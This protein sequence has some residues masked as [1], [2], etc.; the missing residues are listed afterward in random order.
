[1]TNLHRTLR[2]FGILA[3]LASL[4]VLAEGPSWNLGGALINQLDSA[5]AITNN[6][7]GF[8]FSG[9]ADWK[10]GQNYTVRTG[11]AVNY[12]AGS[13]WDAPGWS[14]NGVKTNLMGLQAFGDLHIPTGN[15][16]LHLVVGLSMQ[17]W[18][19]ST[20]KP[21][22]S[23]SPIQNHASDPTSGNIQGI[24]FGMRA[25]L[26]WRFSAKWSGELMIQQTE[27]GNWNKY[28]EP[29]GYKEQGVVFLTNENPGWIQIGVRY[30]F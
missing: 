1:M 9:A 5:K 28:D 11:L 27:L 25:G 3:G 29:R 13:A 24:K 26:D 2:V 18:R 15:K 8:A 14:Y 17:Q 16:D 6:G 21:A 22:A 7:L 23:V 19:F 20:T 30:H 10:T 4:P 12:L